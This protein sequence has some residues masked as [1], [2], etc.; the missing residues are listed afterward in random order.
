MGCT[1]TRAQASVLSLYD[2]DK[3]KQ[4][5]LAGQDATFDQVDDYVLKSLEASQSAEQKSCSAYSFN[6]FSNFQKII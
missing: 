4:P 5:K 3:V 6:A 2:N 1:S